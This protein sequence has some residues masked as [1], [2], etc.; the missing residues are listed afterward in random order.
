VRNLS[1]GQLRLD[2]YPFAIRDLNELG[3]QLPGR[4]T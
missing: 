4:F 2:E 3:G 1:D